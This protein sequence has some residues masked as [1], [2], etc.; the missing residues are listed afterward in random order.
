MAVALAEAIRR[1]TTI[2][3]L[4]KWPNDIVVGQ[5]KLAGILTE[6]K[7]AGE[8][9]D[10]AVVGIGVN[11][12]NE[13]DGI[14]PEAQFPPTS[15]KAETGAAWDINKILDVVLQRIVLCYE[16]FPNAMPE[17]M[18]EWNGLAA[19]VGKRVVIDTGADAITGIAM[20]VDQTGALIIR[21]VT[22]RDRVVI[23][24]AL[25]VLDD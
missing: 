17:L 18:D 15:L 7:T 2:E 5:K 6:M 16:R 10:Y 4:I 21:D 19:A 24:G 25:R 12:N 22:G 1:E 9:V 3:A 20:G 13:F 11:V 14:S 8:A 23:A